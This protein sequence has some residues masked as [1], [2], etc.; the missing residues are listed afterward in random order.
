MS[1]CV[2][3]LSAKTLVA[4]ISNAYTLLQTNSLPSNIIHKFYNGDYYCQK[5][6]GGGG[7][8]PRQYWY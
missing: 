6:G 2:D 3:P 7:D 5:S 1:V 4:Y 8:G